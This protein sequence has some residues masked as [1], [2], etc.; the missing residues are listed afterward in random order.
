M[1]SEEM[2]I[3]EDDRLYIEYYP[4]QTKI[5]HHRAATVN[6]LFKYGFAALFG[7]FVF[8]LMTYYFNYP[9]KY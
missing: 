6:P 8:W 3:D 1:R 5:K 2:N 7:T 9:H 4:T